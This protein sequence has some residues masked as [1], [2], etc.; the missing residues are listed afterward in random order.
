MTIHTVGMKWPPEEWE[1][2][3]I[4]TPTGAKRMRSE[5]II[6]Q[7]C[8]AQFGLVVHALDRHGI[9]QLRA[10]RTAL[11]KDEPTTQDL[12]ILGPDQDEMIW[13][14]KRSVVRLFLSSTAE[15]SADASK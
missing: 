6:L 9:K 14:V 4:L 2:L 15:G 12:V 10:A 7:A 13:I 5:E 1:E 3:F 11:A 8:K